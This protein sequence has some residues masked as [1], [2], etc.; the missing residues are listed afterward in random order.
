MCTCIAGEV[1]T[2]S[3]REKK[4]IIEDRRVEHIRSSPQ[5]GLP[6]TEPCFPSY[7]LRSRVKEDICT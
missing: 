6:L 5:K 3:A 1:M 7:S 2:R 4:G